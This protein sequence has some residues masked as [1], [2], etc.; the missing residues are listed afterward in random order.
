MLESVAAWDK[1]NQTRPSVS[2]AKIIDSLGI[3]VFKATLPLDPLGAHVF[4]M[5]LVSFNQV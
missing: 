3:T 2:K 4:R 1:E 5:K